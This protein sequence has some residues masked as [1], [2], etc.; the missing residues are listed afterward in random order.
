MLKTIAFYFV[1]ISAGLA[2]AAAEP[3]V[4][5]ATIT[6]AHVSPTLMVSGTVQSRFQSEVSA[7]IG[8]TLSW[9]AEPGT[10]V[11]AGQRLA[12]IEQRPF[13]LAVRELEARIARKDIDIKRLT[14]DLARF[15]ELHNSQS[16]SS[17]E[18]DNLASDL[19]VAEADKQLLLVSLDHALDDLART[20]IV[21]PFDGRVAE[22]LHNP[23]EAVS[24]TEAVVRLINT[25]SLEINFHGPLQYSRF[26]DALGQ[27]TVYFGDGS[28]TMPIRAIMPVSNRQ[29]QSFTGYLSIPVEFAGRFRVG[30][31][32]SVAV[33]TEMP[34][35]QFIVPRDALVLGDR[36][37]QVYV[38]DEA[39]KALGIPIAIGADHG[40]YV[41]V[42]GS[43][44]AGQKVIV[45]GAETIASGQQV[46]VLTAADYP[47]TT[48]SS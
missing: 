20:R 28:A 13:Q 33:P 7:G 16:V 25:E 21:A 18:V 11:E 29:S 6:S 19:A 38:L 31:L 10:L 14:R 37:T 4:S 15:R 8:G 41:S 46:T 17:R 32:I 43:L 42:A 34:S 40:D 26:P 36:Q 2:H 3:V 44:A 27:L 12:R 5:V 47:V 48:L 45:R 1:L 24:A 9:V 39:G 30:E 35:E 22:R 23:G